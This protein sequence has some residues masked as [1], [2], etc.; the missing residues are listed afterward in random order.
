MPV[1][2]DVL[3]S[4]GDGE[5]IDNAVKRFKREVSSVRPSWLETDRRMGPVICGL[6]VT[7]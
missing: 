6:R 5:N 3:V 4:V 2:A 7:F 1:S